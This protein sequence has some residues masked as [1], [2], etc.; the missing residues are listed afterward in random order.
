VLLICLD[1]QLESYCLAVLRRERRP[2]C[3]FL[4]AQAWEGSGRCMGVSVAVQDVVPSSQSR[5]GGFGV[6]VRRAAMPCLELGSLPGSQL[7]G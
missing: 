5:V 7:W 1:S 4:A 6:L 2:T 3:S